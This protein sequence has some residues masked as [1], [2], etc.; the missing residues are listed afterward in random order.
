MR[1][2]FEVQDTAW[3]GEDFES[4]DYKLIVRTG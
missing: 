2:E 4:I 3:S 1:K